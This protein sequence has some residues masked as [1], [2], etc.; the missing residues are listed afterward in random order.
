MDPYIFGAFAL[1][2]FGLL[3]WLVNKQRCWTLMSVLLAVALSLVYDNGIL[4]FGTWIGEGSL[5]EA[6]SAA[7][8]WLHAIVTPTL[9]LFSLEAMR[10]AGIRWAQKSWATIL[11]WMAT[12]GAVI[13][14]YMTVLKN[15]EL[16]PESSYG[17]LSYTSAESSTGPPAMVLMVLVALLIAGIFL[18]WNIGS[19]WMLAGTLIM[20]TGSLFSPDIPSE[21]ATNL[22]ELILIA[23]LAKTKGL[24]EASAHP[25]SESG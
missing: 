6:L 7:R 9:I 20:T 5:L 13:I 17:V 4:A 22:F 2:Y 1:S 21:A 19:W 18:V 23:S 12:A 25:S 24:L 3:I 16:V 10:Q 8:F 14:E 15:L 11:F